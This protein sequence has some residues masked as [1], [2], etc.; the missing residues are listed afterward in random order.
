MKLYIVIL[1]SITIVFV[2][3]DRAFSQH[4]YE[5]DFEIG[6]AMYRKLKFDALGDHWHTGMFMYFEYD[7][8]IGTMSFSQQAGGFW[9]Q[10]DFASDKLEVVYVNRNIGTDV[11]G[12][13]SLK[14]DFIDKFETETNEPYYGAY[15]RNDI[16]PSIRSSIAST[17]KELGNNTVIDYTSTYMLDPENHWGYYWGWLPGWYENWTG[18]IGDI[19]EIRCDGIIEYSY[20]KHG[21]MVSNNDNLAHAGNSHPEKHNEFHSGIPTTGFGQI[22]PKIQSG[23]RNNF[24]F[25]PPWEARSEFE[26]LITSAP[27]TSNISDDG[28]TNPQFSFNVSDNASVKAY[29]LMQVRKLGT[30]SWRT[31]VDQTGNKWQFRGVNLTDWNGSLQSDNFHVIWDGAYSGGT[32]LDG[33]DDYQLKITVIDQGANYSESAV[34][35]FEAT[36]SNF[37]VTVAGPSALDPNIQGTFTAT[38]SGGT[39]SYNNYRWYIFQGTGGTTPSSAGGG[40]W[41]EQT[42]W[43][44]QTTVQYASTDNFTIMCEVTSGG[45]TIS[46]VQAVSVTGSGG[47][48]PMDIQE[49]TDALNISAALSASEVP[50][51]MTLVGNY[52]NPFKETTII[53]FGLPADENVVLSIYSVTGQLVATVASGNFVAGYH[54]VEW[55]GLTMDG[56]LLSNGV[57]L[58]KL[59]VAGRVITKKMVLAR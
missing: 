2:D 9:A 29:V 11:S 13:A 51:T 46:N 42:A 50:E 4:S 56:N 21:V 31:L 44:N 8:G 18:G 20:E 28:S 40:S 25:Q 36:L 53:K 17:A 48:T 47:S 14:L 26:Q 1:F 30:S 6:T 3:L 24:L 41:V 43:H 23:V 32:Y 55:N 37:A 49:N 45:N 35:D 52:P 12:L 15:S 58:Y 59:Q 22:C 34:Y 19:D 33:T 38:A 27:I 16:S 5:N 39:G 54:E 7:Y 57:Y 10:S